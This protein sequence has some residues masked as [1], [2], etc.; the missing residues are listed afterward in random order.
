MIYNSASSACSW[1][2]H[3]VALLLD[4]HAPGTAGREAPSSV[5]SKPVTRGCVVCAQ[6]MVRCTSPP[7]APP[8]TSPDWFL[9]W[10][11][12]RT[13]AVV[14]GATDDKYWCCHVGAYGCCVAIMRKRWL[15]P[16]A[17]KYTTTSK[18]VLGFIVHVLISD[19]GS[20]AAMMRLQGFTI[21]EFVDHHHCTAGPH[22]TKHSVV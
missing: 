12:L 16:S 1:A 17:G 2:I 4:R 14:A 7:R 18:Q 19:S 10:T 22:R 8:W 21:Q 5:C 20:C 3:D 13:P 6:A 9:S 11:T 15:K